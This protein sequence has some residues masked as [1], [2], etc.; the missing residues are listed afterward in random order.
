MDYLLLGFLGP[1]P[2]LLLCGFFIF[3]F[4]HINFSIPTKVFLL[5]MALLALALGSNFFWILPYPQFELAFMAILYGSILFG[6]RRI[7]LP[8]PVLTF[9]RVFSFMGFVISSIGL[10]IMSLFLFEH[11]IF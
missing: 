4:K 10:F 6:I 1:L 7:N 3:G 5:L 9:L 11:L 8:V 2:A